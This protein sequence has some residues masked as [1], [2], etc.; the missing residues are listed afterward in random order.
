LAGRRLVE[1]AAPFWGRRPWLA[2]AAALVACAV[3]FAVW[4][5]PKP[6]TDF[7]AY[8]RDMTEFLTSELDSLDF[9]N[10]DVLQVQHWLAERHSHGDLVV[11]AGLSGGRSIGCRI[12]D[13]QGRKVTLVCFLLGGVREVHLFVIDQSDLIHPPIGSRP[14]F[15]ND[16]S[17]TTAAWS[18][19]GKTYLVA[20][21]G[22]RSFLERCF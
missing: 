15:R 20:G 12:L 18:E 5:A 13:W 9:L 2:L 14:V 11:P 8:E 19:Q 21:R 16:G 7:S 3:L 17:W 22:D 1:P 4:M 6:P 10:P